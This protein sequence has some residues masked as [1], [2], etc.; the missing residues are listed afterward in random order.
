MTETDNSVKIYLVLILTYLSLRAGG[1]AIHSG[2]VRW[3]ATA[4]RASR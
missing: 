3:I 2:M 4:L 1:E